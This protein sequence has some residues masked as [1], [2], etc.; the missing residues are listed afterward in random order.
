MSSHPVN[1]V[2]S[3]RAFYKALTRHSSNE[4]LSEL[5]E[6]KNELKVANDLKINEEQNTNASG[7]P[8][9]KDQDFY[10]KEVFFNSPKE[11]DWK[12]VKS[13][14]ELKQDALAFTKLRKLNILE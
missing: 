8:Y 7:S 10:K 14:E 11:T 6:I 12:K 1:K 3:L 4:S 13:S 2:D 5:K 9:L